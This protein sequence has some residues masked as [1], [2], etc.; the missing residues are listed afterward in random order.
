[1]LVMNVFEADS[2]EP[3]GVLA[4]GTYNGRRTGV[5]VAVKNASRPD[6][7]HA[8]WAYYDFTDP[9]DPTKTL[10][11]AS[12]FADDACEACHKLHAKTDHVWVQFYPMLRDR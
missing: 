12:A 9:S 7:S 8:A 2:S 6:G 3:Q 5:E 1:V 4:T 11:S 10:A